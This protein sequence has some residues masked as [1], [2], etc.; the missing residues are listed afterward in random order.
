MSS[1]TSKPQKT[2]ILMIKVTEKEIIMVQNAQN[3]FQQ[4]FLF[5]LENTYAVSMIFFLF[6]HALECSV[7]HF[8]GKAGRF[9][10]NKNQLF[11]HCTID[12]LML[13][14]VAS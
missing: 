10:E 3:L 1:S 2:L 14:L 4:S 7:E 8:R 6:F 11:H 9:S 12:H 13:V 5:L